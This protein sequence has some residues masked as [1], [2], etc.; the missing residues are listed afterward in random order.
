MRAGAVKKLEREVIFLLVSHSGASKNWSGAERRRIL[1]F[2]L[3]R[4]KL[5]D[6]GV[7][8]GGGGTNTILTSKKP[9]S[10]DAG[11]DSGRR[12]V[13]QVAQSRLKLRAY[14]ARRKRP[15]LLRRAAFA[16]VREP[17]PF[18]ALLRFP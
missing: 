11:H 4:L 13:R 12:R 17:R 16:A 5:K 2:K 1:R 18:R 6:Y 14:P 15:L 7:A 9:A 3:P 8:S 10:Y